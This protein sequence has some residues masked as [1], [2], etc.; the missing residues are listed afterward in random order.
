MSWSFKFL[1]PSKA[2]AVAEL[3]R[4]VATDPHRAVGAQLTLDIVQTLP[5]LPGA[6]LMIDTAGHIGDG[7]WSSVKMD[8]S[9]VTVVSEPVPAA[10]PAPRRIGDP[11]PA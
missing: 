3:A 11:V 8:I 7:T 4:I 6:G 9:H 10:E 5:E 1:A 2:A